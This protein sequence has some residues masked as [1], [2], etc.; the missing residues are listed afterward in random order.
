MVNILSIHHIHIRMR[1]PHAIQNVQ[2]GSHVPKV[3]SDYNNNIKLG[4]YTLLSKKATVYMTLVCSLSSDAL[5]ILP[6]SDVLISKVS[7][8][9]VS[10]L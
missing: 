4:T 6:I 3:Q 8:E 10:I 1:T 2:N 9:N 7:L 5:K